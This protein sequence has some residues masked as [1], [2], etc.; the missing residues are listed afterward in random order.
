MELKHLGR[1]YGQAADQLPNTV[2][3][4]L[5]EAAQYVAG[6]MKIEISHTWHA[7][8]T[9]AMLNSVRPQ[10]DGSHAYL[11]GPTQSYSAYV[12]LGTS[13]MA[14]RPFHISTY[15]KVLPRLENLNITASLFN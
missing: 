9:G 2:D 4:A 7:V 12:A 11:I 6:V 15:N 3:K 1:L 5:S 14:A 10:K 13:K 8:D